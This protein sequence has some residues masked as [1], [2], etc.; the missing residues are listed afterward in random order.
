MAGTGNRVST[1]RTNVSSRTKGGASTHSLGPMDKIAAYLINHQQVGVETLRNLLST[2]LTSLMTWMV[3]GIALAL[4][5]IL[6]IL[7]AN[8]GNLGGEWDGKPKLSLYLAAQT[9]EKAGIALSEELARDPGVAMTSYITPA[10][11]LAEFQESTGFDDVLASLPRNPL[12]AVIEIELEALSPAETKLKVTQ[13]ESHNFAA[14]RH[15]I[16]HTLSTDSQL[17]IPLLRIRRLGVRVF[18]GA[19]DLKN[20]SFLPLPYAATSLWCR[21]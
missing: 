1:T 10:R 19:P 11:A 2:M 3:I 18:P 14:L 12:P 9:S 21:H 15:F 8:I 7:L 17:V 6:Y 4:P 16:A 20:L 13:L 5:A